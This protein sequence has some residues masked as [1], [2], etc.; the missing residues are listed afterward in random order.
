VTDRQKRGSPSD[1]FPP[2]TWPTFWRE[3]LQDGAIPVVNAYAAAIAERIDS[4]ATRRGCSN[5]QLSALTGVTRNTLLYLRRG[6]RYCDSPTLVK[7]D[8]TLGISIW[9]GDE[10]RELLATTAQDTD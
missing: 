4:E 6:E 2:G 5:T 7:L 8:Q 3:L 1:P 10:V 9:P